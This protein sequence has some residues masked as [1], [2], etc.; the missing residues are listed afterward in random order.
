MMCSCVVSFG[1]QASIPTIPAGNGPIRLIGSQAEADRNDEFVTWQL[2]RSIATDSPKP[3][4]GH[5]VVPELVDA[6]D[7]IPERTKREATGNLIHGACADN[8]EKPR[9]Q[10]RLEHSGMLFVLRFGPVQ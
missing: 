5:G 1:A 7:V 3:L 2:A 9:L 6:A 8:V 10:T 4:V